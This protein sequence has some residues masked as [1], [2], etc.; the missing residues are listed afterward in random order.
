MKYKHF[1]WLLTLLVFCSNQSGT[2]ILSEPYYFKIDKEKVGIKEEWYEED[3]NLELL[4]KVEQL[5]NWERFLSMEYDGWGW[6]FTEFDYA[7]KH[8]K[9]ALAF[10]SVDDDAQIWLNGQFVGTHKGANTEFKFDVSDFL[11]KGKNRL[12]ILVIDFGGQGG[13]IGKVALVP[14]KNKSNLSKGKYYYADTPKP[15]E[16][17]ENAV[18]YELNTRQFTLEGTFQAIEPRIEELKELGVKIIWFMPI[19]P[20]GEKKRKGTLGSY[21]AVRDFYG[22]NPEFGTL[23][24]FRSLVDKIHQ[25][26][27]YVII[28]LVANHTA[29]D[30][31]LIEQHPEWYTRD[32][33]GNIVPPVKDWSDV[34]DLNY[35]NRE[36]WG[37][38]IDVMKYW[39][40]EIDIDGY[41]CDVA[42]MVPTEF[43]VKARNELDKIKPVFMLAEAETPE[44]NANGFDMT[45]AS[46]MYH[47][48]NNIANGKKSPEQIDAL[49]RHEQN[50]YPKNS[51]RMRFT[52]NHDENSW[53]QSAITR[54]GE[55]GAQTFAVLTF[56]L[57]GTPLIY[58]GQEIGNRKSLEFFEKDPIIWKESF[59]R[60]FYQTL[61]HAYREFPALYRGNFVKS[62]TSQDDIIYA[63]I[64]TENS[65][66]V[67]IMTNLSPNE[68]TTEID[69]SELSGQFIEL[70]TGEELAIIEQK[71][72]FILEPWEYR[73]YV[74]KKQNTKP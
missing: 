60:S 29:W 14:F 11:R 41:R 20:I 32:E 42:A 5:K 52:S 70:F 10:S 19:H 68:I 38:M 28:D 3:F 12:T 53:H 57:P 43:W 8:R 23:A 45:Y 6:Y 48:F 46:S 58:N 33:D 55:K 37:Y 13:V 54:L 21:Y 36:V 61:A 64:R 67:L 1:F 24:D 31:P 44:L 56:T 63:F 59:F 7:E 47:L 34:A 27:I 51:M 69:L 74:Q 73:V 26:E 35:G 49:L 30:N 15:P 72:T 25:N 50:H 66:F 62:R 18:I 9:L 22:I 65:E 17:S 71:L 39:V 16:W 4:T 2:I 40:S